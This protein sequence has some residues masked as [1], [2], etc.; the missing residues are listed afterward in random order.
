VVYTLDVINYQWGWANKMNN[1]KPTLDWL[2]N[3]EIFR[4]N[5]IDA[6]SD[7]WFYEKM[8]HIRLE[9]NMPLKQNLNGKWRFSYSENPSLRIKDFYKEDLILM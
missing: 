1:I 2:E 9:D 7:H 8:E 3:P 5:R 4:V 6:H